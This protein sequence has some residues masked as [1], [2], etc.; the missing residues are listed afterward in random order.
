VPDR[1]S[2]AQRSALMA[3]IRSRDT[4]PEI[5][6][7]RVLHAAGFRFRLHRRDLPGSPDIVLPRHR[8]VVFVH[9]CFWHRHRRCRDGQST[10]GSNVAYWTT[11]F[12]RN[13]RRDRRVKSALRKL[14]WR[15]VTVWECQL[16]RDPSRVLAAV[17]RVL[18]KGSGADR[19]VGFR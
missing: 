15:V 4:S 13:L 9:G 18:Q 12:E 16:R 17:G 10:P 2:T 3:R 8:T 1:L 7:R 19:G 14:G 11:K 6:A 5:A